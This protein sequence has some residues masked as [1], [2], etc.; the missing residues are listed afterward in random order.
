MVAYVLHGALNL[1]VRKEQPLVY[2]F[3][4]HQETTVNFA[5]KRFCCV[6][7]DF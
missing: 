3:S 7:V 1:G 4:C 5:K 6:P 2:V